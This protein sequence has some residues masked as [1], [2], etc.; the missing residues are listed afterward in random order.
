MSQKRSRSINWNEEEKQLLRSVLKQYSQ[1]IENKSLSTNTNTIK[2][3]AWE[4][5]HT[6]F[7]ELNSRP[8]ALSQLKHQ[9]KTM[10]INA[11]KT[12]SIFKKEA[13]K[14]GG[15]ARPTSPS[16]AI[17]EVKDLLN[18]A[19]LLRD[20]NVYDSDGIII[21]EFDNPSTSKTFAIEVQDSPL[22]ENIQKT[23]TAKIDNENI[24]ISDD[25]IPVATTMKKNVPKKLPKRRLL[26]S[27]NIKH[28][29]KTRK[30]HGDY[31]DNIIEHS[32]ML[33][34]DEHKRRMEMAEEEHAIKMEIYRQQ[35]K[36]V[37]MEAE[38]LKIKISCEHF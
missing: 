19:E 17:I 36:N 7:N 23:N 10:K 8:R 25:D 13:N 34:E 32:K 14:T 30:D 28:G 24:V 27:N 20:H 31:V 38:I 35:L 4:E 16:D 3:K 21:A 29:N 5:I 1:I 37:S 9:W 18:P 26:A 22:L 2:T 6:K 33:K 12:Y 15:G 11:R